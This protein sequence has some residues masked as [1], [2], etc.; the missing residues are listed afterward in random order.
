MSWVKQRFEFGVFSTL[1]VILMNNSNE[2][3]MAERTQQSD[4]TSAYLLISN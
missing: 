4:R 2:L 3:F 1:K